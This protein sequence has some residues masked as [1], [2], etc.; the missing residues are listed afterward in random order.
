MF[1]PA[2]EEGY[3]KRGTIG[4]ATGPVSQ[5]V[6]EVVDAVIESVSRIPRLFA[7]ECAFRVVDNSPIDTGHFVT[8]WQAGIG[9]IPTS[10]VHM[11]NP[12]KAAV[13]KKSKYGDARTH[14]TNVGLERAAVKRRM[15]DAIW[16]AQPGQEIRIQNNTKY[17]AALE[18]GHSKSQA[19]NGVV[20]PVLNDAESILNAI[21]AGEI[22]HLSQNRG[23]RGDTMP[24][25]P[26]RGSKGF[27]E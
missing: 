22:G 8:N 26:I 5:A 21:I 4:F 24:N 23:I 11:M 15:R 7:T 14:F 20:T 25:S 1:H 18:T 27:S 3:G 19:P 12:V 13:T 16:K 10:E 6:A 17:A 9:N 2:V